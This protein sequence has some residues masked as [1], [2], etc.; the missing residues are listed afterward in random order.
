MA[1]IS[2]ITIMNTLSERELCQTFDKGILLLYIL[3]FKEAG[4][5]Y[6]YIYVAET[7]AAKECSESSNIHILHALRVIAV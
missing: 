1:E 3:T 2:F 6:I 7:I 5:W 4:G